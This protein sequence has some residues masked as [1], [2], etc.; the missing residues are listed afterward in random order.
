MKWTAKDIEKL[1]L[2]NNLEQ[3]S[4]KPNSPDFEGIKIE[5]V[6][7]EKNTIAKVLWVMHREGEIPEYVTELVFHPDRKFRFDWAIPSLKIAIEYEGVISKK[8]RHTT[9]K[10]YSTDC[11]KYNLALVSGW[12][13]L[14]DTAMN[15]Q[16]LS[17]DLKS[18]LR[19]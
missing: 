17:E 6:S 11:E 8:S 4:K 10:G 19:K 15:Y 12:K 7:V 14:R 13:V 16:N 2:N 9:M 18:L 1:K 5:K 3:V